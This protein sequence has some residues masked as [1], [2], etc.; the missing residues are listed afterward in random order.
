[1]GVHKKLLLHRESKGKHR[2]QGQ[3]QAHCY[4]EKA[5]GNTGL[6]ANHKLTDK[7]IQLPAFSKMSVP[8]A[9][10]TLSHS[11]AAEINM[12]VAMNA[13]PPEAAYTADFCEKMDQLFDSVNSRKRSIR[14]MRSKPYKAAVTASTGH[15]NFWR[16]NIKWLQSWKIDSSHIQ[17]VTG[18][19]LTLTVLILLWSELQDRCNFEFLLVSRCN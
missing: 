12:A 6:R 8:L 19:I 4:I 10:Q 3:S 5:R 16:E 7:H 15:V 14:E 2:S 13:L 17:C 1:M 18:W 9:A 11:V